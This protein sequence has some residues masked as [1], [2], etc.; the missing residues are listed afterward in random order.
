MDEQEIYSFIQRCRGLSYKFAGVFAADNFP[1]TLPNNSFIIVNAS[2]SNS[3][4]SHWLLL[5]RK[6]K[7]YLFADPLGF[8]MS[9]YTDL[10]QRLETFMPSIEDLTFNRPMQSENSTMC[11]LYCIYF[12]YNILNS[13]GPIEIPPLNELQ[14]T[15]FASNVL[16]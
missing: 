14:L 7:Y 4:G 9:T 3:F 13:V 16:L 1:S 12:A 15:Q 2:L 11:G 10:C 6:D 8:P 5:C